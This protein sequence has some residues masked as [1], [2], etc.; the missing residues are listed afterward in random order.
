MAC[1]LDDASRRTGLRARLFLTGALLAV[2]AGCDA[3]G[4]DT[5]R[6]PSAP[7]A[8]CTKPA[9]MAGTDGDN[10][11][12]AA[13]VG[14]L[15]E[16]ISVPG[17]TDNPID[18]EGSA[19]VDID[20]DGLTDVFVVTTDGVHLYLNKGCFEFQ[21]Q[22]IEFLGGE[23]ELARAAIPVF[24]DFND[25]GLL[26]WYL[27]RSHEPAGLYLARGNA[28]TFEDAAERM[29]VTGKGA[30]KR[31]AQIADLNNDGWLDIAVGSDQI[32]S[33]VNSGVD[34][35]FLFIYE[36]A[37]SGRFEDGTFE[38]IGG[39][40]LIPDFG[41]E[42]ACD[43][44]VDRASPSILVRDLDDDGDLDIVQPVHVDM[45]LSDW[46]D[47]C[48]TGE[49]RH[50]VWAWKNLLKETGS[51]RFEKQTPEGGLAEEA[52]NKYNALT[53]VYDP[54]GSAVSHPYG[55]S[56]DVDN[57]GD[58][59][60]ITIGP[61]DPEWH[62]Q[63]DPIAGKFW[64]NEGAFRFAARTE[65]Q[66]LGP[67][68]WMYD[69]WVAFWDAG[70]VAPTSEI[71]TLGCLV[72]SNQIP[73]CAPLTS[74][75]HHFYMADAI[76]ADFNNDGWLDL[77]IADRHEVSTAWDKLRNVLFMNKGDGTFEPV[78]T[79]VSGIDV[80][81]IA[82]EVAD[83][84]NDGLIDLFLNASPNN[85]YPVFR[86]IPGYVP[87]ERKIDKLYWNTGQLGGLDNHWLKVRLKGLPFRKLVGTKLML[88]DATT[89]RLLGRRDLFP[90][91]SYKSSH[92]DEIHFGAGQH[93]K[94]ELELTL[95]S[96]EQKTIH[97]LPIDTLIDLNVVTGL[98]EV[99]MTPKSPRLDPAAE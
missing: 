91:D 47:P 34:R 74:V 4:V 55:N 96:G 23:I 7:T 32:G 35:H 94:L 48:A 21:E 65:E 19:L 79:Q 20:R 2:L 54:V 72:Y 53:M 30:Y 24:A 89:G 57:D 99:P 42:P 13:G 88:K 62:V 26:D 69:R 39:T 45:N 15:L 8:A 66:G 25:D 9:L 14:Q 28:F 93:Q 97:P 92:G 3:G 49:Q 52:H 83:L 33:A 12:D 40:D 31:Q 17:V 46:D 87:K 58:L 51:F 56:A 41:S 98:V 18:T 63:T 71:Q 16:R 43:V 22:A 38:N 1:L 64:R 6:L 78:T 81:S 80:N 73:K 68:N 76:F 95:P 75:E 37:P 11:A 84:N 44:T 50:G 85:S 70:V 82:G 61:T 5:A 77:V 27:T 86:Q 60:I 29:G 67:L 36:P 10:T 90:V 59:D